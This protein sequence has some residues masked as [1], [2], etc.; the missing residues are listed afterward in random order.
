LGMNHLKS[1]VESYRLATERPPPPGQILV[2]SQIIHQNRR[3]FE[4][5]RGFRAWWTTPGRKFVVCDCGWRA[6]L[7]KHYRVQRL[8]IRRW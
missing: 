5:S 6:D 8:P 1:L 4:G 7:G 2:H 3:L